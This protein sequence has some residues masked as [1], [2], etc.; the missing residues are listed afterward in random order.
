MYDDHLR[1]KIESFLDANYPCRCGDA[2]CP[3]NYHEAV[4]IAEMVHEHDADDA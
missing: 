4:I 3:G 1:K 2:D